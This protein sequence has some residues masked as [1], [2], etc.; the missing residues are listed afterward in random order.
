MPIEYPTTSRAD[1]VEDYHGEA[2]AD[3]YR[4]LEDA[5]APETAAWIAS[6]NELTESLLS[7][8]GTRSEIAARVSEL[9]DYPRAAAPFEH[10]G[11]WFQFRN[12]GLQAQPVLYVASEPDAAGEILLDPNG[13]SSE[14]TVAVSAAVPSHDGRLLA[15]AT[16][17]AGSDWNTWRVREVDSGRDLDDVVEWSKFSVASWHGNGAF[18]YGS[19]ERPPSGEEYE[20]EL[21]GQRVMIHQLGTSPDADE[22]LYSPEEQEWLPHGSMTDDGRYLVIET[23]R[24]TGHEVRL[25]VIDMDKGGGSILIV[26]DFSVE[27]TVIGNREDRFFL[28]TDDGA[29]RRRV[30][31]ADLSA[32]GREHWIELIGEK[33]ETLVGARHCGANIVCWYLRDAQAV[34]RVHD[35]DGVFVREIE[36]PPYSSLV[37]PGWCPPVSGHP[38]LDLIHFAVTSYTRSDSV[39]EHDLTNGSTRVVRESSAPFDSAQFVT[40]RLYATSEDGTRVPL[41]CTHHR[42]VV[43][44]GEVPVLLYGY[45]GFDIPLTPSFSVEA[46]VFMERGGLYCVANLRGGGEFGT[47]WHHSGRLANKQNVFDDFTA[48]ARH[49]CESG[50]TRADRIAINGGSNGGLLVAACLTQHPDAF[51][52]AVP[53]VGVHDMLRFHR[54]T[55]GWAWKSDFGDPDDPV[56]YRWLRAYSPLH[57]VR[58]GVAYPPTLITTGDHD[59]RVVPGHSLKFAATLQAAQAGDGPILLRVET[60][61]GH[62]AG[63]PTWKRIEER[64]DVLAFIEAAL[65]L[66]PTA[67]GPAGEN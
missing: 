32:P 13:L 47:S 46:A 2:I 25:E 64:T 54:F 63:K 48:S 20:A 12:T 14:G 55:I 41:F 9:W 22:V 7:S 36:I 67:F 10:G 53:E 66:S 62:G 60:A 19:P 58:Q 24:G 15:Y 30:V 6:Q 34:L 45:G 40:E 28:L 42:D 18:V 37:E 44:N 61:A 23:T 57:N 27:A 56:A 50:W 39:L 4:W 26:P 5:D 52:A 33:E 65:G 11:R 16:S 59:D 8:I 31:A 21:R 3:P 29:E 1:D 38:G 49:L 17:G 35:L 51:G 43:P